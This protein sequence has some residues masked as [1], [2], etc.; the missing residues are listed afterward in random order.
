MIFKIFQGRILLVRLIMIFAMAA[1][2]AIGII[3]IYSAAPQSGYWKKQIFFASLGVLAFIIAN[4]V[5]YKDLGPISYWLYGILL[6]ILSI[7]L[8]EKFTTK[9]GLSMPSF[10]RSF[11]PYIN[12]SRRWIRLGFGSASI[13]L[14]PSEFCKIAHIL[15]LAWYLRFRSNY[16]KI[17]GLIGPF[18]LTLLAMILILLEPDLGTVLLMMPV[19]FSMLFVAGAKIKHLLLI[20]ALAVIAS[21]FLWMN[22]HD[23]QRMRI[24]SVVLQIDK[25]YKAAEDNP[26][27]ANIFAGSS[28]N[29][30]RWK[31]DKGYHLRH[32]KYAISSGG[33]MGYGFKNG[34]YITA[35]NVHLPESH[36]DFIFALIAHQWGLI[37][38]LGLFTLYLLLAICGL[39]IAWLNTDP[40]GRLVAVGIVT[41][42][43]V[44]VIVNVSMT[45]GLMPITGLTLPFVSYGGSSLIV[46]MTA[47]GLLNNIGRDRPF[48]LAGKAF[49][50]QKANTI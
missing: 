45:M 32:S 11:V 33:I 13:Q 30:K 3:C 35:D 20:I 7:L 36:N 22:M 19:L 12:G 50:H 38:C 17:A 43:M 4:L 21:P 46:S 6:V 37:G 10:W 49:E 44:M 27:L 9:L 24:S 16:T 41:M 25:V 34:P 31:K 29:L 39:E 18:A 14:Q 15:A 23:Y 48:S 8:I 26:R 5:H 40:F 1:L 2:L 42:F 47:V 28:A